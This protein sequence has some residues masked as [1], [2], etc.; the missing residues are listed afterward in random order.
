[1]WLGSQLRRVG[2]APHGTSSF[3]RLALAFSQASP[4]IISW[5][6]HSSKKKAQM[7]RHDFFLN[8]VS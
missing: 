3:K 6:S 5:Q 4:D 7:L 2:S 8:Q 1:M